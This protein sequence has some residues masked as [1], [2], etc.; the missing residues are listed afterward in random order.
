MSRFRSCL[1]A[2]TLVLVLAPYVAHAG[3]IIDADFEAFALGSPPP[4]GPLPD[5]PFQ[6]EPNLVVTVENSGTVPG[7]ALSSGNFLRMGERPGE[8]PNLD[9]DVGQSFDTGV[10]RVGMDLLFEN[11]ENYN[12]YFRNG[13]GSGLPPN[14]QSIA[15]V[16]FGE[17]GD[18]RFVSL[19]GAWSTTYTTGSAIRLEA[20]FD[21]NNDRWN[22][23]LNGVQIVSD[24]TI[25]DGYLGRIGVGFEFTSFEPGPGFDGMMQLDNVVMEQVPEPGMLGLLGMGLA[26]VAALR[27][28]R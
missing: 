2:A 28:R 9:F 25:M 27:R 11:L 15:T 26:G 1:P 19:G 18:V 6:I 16:G 24:E 22:A 5:R 10:L 23:F 4:T 14:S 17:S 13:V 12:V 3:P 7:P 21:M 20:M 8:A